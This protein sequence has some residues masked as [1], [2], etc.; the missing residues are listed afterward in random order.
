[1]F[2]NK[3]GFT[4]VELVIVIAVIGILAGVL[5]P[6]F[7]GITQKAEESKALQATRNTLTEYLSQNSGADEGMM[8]YYAMKEDATSTTYKVYLYANGGL[9]D[10]GTIVCN[11]SY[12]VDTSKTKW[13]DGFSYDAETKLISYNT[14]YGSFTYVG[15][16]S[17]GAD[18][19]GTY[20][21]AEIS[22]T[23]QCS[24]TTTESNNTDETTAAE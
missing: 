16:A 9:H 4:I 10:V 7:S 18:N 6:T 5:I 19:D 8:F 17:F 11:S 2:K 15:S 21:E 1:M 14:E 24:K 3:K 12:A 13:S 20:G 23:S 22:K